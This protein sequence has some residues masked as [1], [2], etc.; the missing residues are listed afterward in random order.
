ASVPVSTKKTFPAGEFETLA[1]RYP[2]IPNTT[3]LMP[4]FPSHCSPSVASTQLKSEWSCSLSGFDGLRGTLS[5]RGTAT[6]A[7]GRY[8]GAVGVVA[9][10]ETCG[11]GGITGF[12]V[13]G[14]SNGFTTGGGG[15]TGAFKG[16]CTAGAFTEA[17]TTS[18]VAFGSTADFSG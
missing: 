4:I 18:G 12:G 13:I 11:A 15:T 14:G 6:R 8:G 16:A 5:K 2:A 17:V 9:I 3:R 1:A 7:V 10:G